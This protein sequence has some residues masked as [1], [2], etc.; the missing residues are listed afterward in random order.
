MV[1]RPRK[2]KSQNAVSELNS[3]GHVTRVT[4]GLDIISPL[5]SLEVMPHIRE[6]KRLRQLGARGGKK[7]DVTVREIDVLV[8]ALKARPEVYLSVDM[9][10]VGRAAMV[11]KIFSL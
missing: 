8:G 6:R 3:G 11:A 9:W 4:C 10:A 1:K 2:K 5:M 7:K